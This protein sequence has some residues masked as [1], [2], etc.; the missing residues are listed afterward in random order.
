MTISITTP[1]T[2]EETRNTQP[3]L[4]RNTMIAFDPAGGCTVRVNIMNPT[5]SPVATPTAHHCGPKTVR[6]IS[7]MIEAD[8]C[9]PTTERGCDKGASGSANSN[10]ADAPN[11]PN[12]I[13]P[14]VLIAM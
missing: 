3:G 5:P 6:Q 9:P 13:S 7:A 14:R 10:N 4:A 12:N 11:E 2:V 1:A 8:T